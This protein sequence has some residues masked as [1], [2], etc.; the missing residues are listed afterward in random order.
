MLRG[1][2]VNIR[3][4]TGFANIPAWEQYPR[5]DLQERLARLKSHIETIAG[6]I[7]GTRMDLAAVQQS[8]DHPHLTQRPQLDE[9]G[10]AHLAEIGW[11]L[12]ARVGDLE[13]L[14]TSLAN[15]ANELQACLDIADRDGSDVPEE[16]PADLASVNIRLQ[17]LQ[18]ELDTFHAA[19]DL[20]DVGW[21]EK[22][23]ALDRRLE[24]VES[25]LHQLAERQE[26]LELQTALLSK[27][28]E[29]ITGPPHWPS[30]GTSSPDD[31]DRAGQRP[32]P[33]SARAA[34]Q[35]QFEQL[36]TSTAQL[37][38]RVE[39]LQDEGKRLERAVANLRDEVSRSPDGGLAAKVD[40]A[41]A[42]GDQLA[43][44]QH[45][46]TDEVAALKAAG[47]SVHDRLIRVEQRN[48]PLQETV[49]DLSLRYARQDNET[50]ALR[51]RLRQRSILGL[52]AFLLV[53]AGLGLAWLRTPMPV[54]LEALT[55]QAEATA[56]RIVQPM[57]AELA[58]DVAELREDV[59]PILVR[60]SDAGER[61]KQTQAEIQAM[62]VQLRQE[63]ARMAGETERLSEELEQ[64]SRQV[65]A[66][67]ER[68]PVAASAD[69]AASAA[70]RLASLPRVSASPA[71]PPKP[72][73]GLEAIWAQARANGHY[74]LQLVGVS[75]RGHM[76]WFLEQHR[77]PGNNA[78]YHARRGGR[79]W[80]EL[81]HG[82]YSTSE[83]A[84]T[85]A[86][87]LPSGLAAQNPWVRRIPASGRLDP[88]Q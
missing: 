63:V 53:L 79:Q 48:N 1:L 38:A 3:L 42:F 27:E 71:V 83:E 67:I 80:L 44:R 77:V 46:L 68:S 23:I 72:P 7:D 81:F 21:E 78:I 12:S 41:A 54:D 40:S 60:L 30:V 88:L 52:V 37:G 25:R 26:S 19:N 76:S 39:G 47:G 28:A 4:G 10:Q 62:S 51:Q 57:M 86:G 64:L 70:P 66:T 8:L 58:R 20:R 2:G 15:A 55:E 34:D 87:K 22:S 45:Q 31:P 18:S 16:L 6:A 59:S 14:A 35:R 84:L 24:G 65:R 75:E 43:Q 56:R 61:W 29:Q 73:S 9:G 85:A 33:R 82:T 36:R 17:A 49:D 50:R 11:A 5:M 69:A 13:K 74:T 32:A